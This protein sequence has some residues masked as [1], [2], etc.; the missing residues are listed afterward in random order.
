VYKQN[1][2]ELFFVTSVAQAASIR[3]KNLEKSARPS[4]GFLGVTLEAPFFVD[5]PTGEEVLSWG[6]AGVPSIDLNRYWLN[7]YAE[8]EQLV[9]A[10]LPKQQLPEWALSSHIL[11]D[12]VWSTGDRYL[13]LINC[14]DT[15]L[16]TLTPTLVHVGVPYSL[17]G[18]ILIAR[19]R[20]MGIRTQVIRGLA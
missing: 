19:A 15:A 2:F 13:K 3:P 6:Q 1:E 17:A 7:H 12:V 8:T 14:A 10:A 11:L 9:R 5:L 4:V 20:R 16:A 18:R